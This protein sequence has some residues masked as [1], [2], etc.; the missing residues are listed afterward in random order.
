MTPPIAPPIKPTHREMPSFHGGDKI[1]NRAAA[2]ETSVNKA[3]ANKATEN[4][5]HLNFIGG[6]PWDGAA[7]GNKFL[8]QNGHQA[9]P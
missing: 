6:N 8:P 1:R 7:S 3:G 5:R 9:A 2:A 4:D